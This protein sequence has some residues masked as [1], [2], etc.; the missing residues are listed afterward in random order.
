[1]VAWVLQYFL[2]WWWSV[3]EPSS[4]VT[5]S[6]VWLLSSWSVASAPEALMFSLYF[7]LSSNNC[8]W[9]MYGIKSISYQCTL[10][11]ELISSEALGHPWGHLLLTSSP[12][13]PLQSG[14]CQEWRHMPCAVVSPGF[15]FHTT[16]KT[17]VCLGMGERSWNPSKWFG[18]YFRGLLFLNHIQEELKGY[19][20]PAS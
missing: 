8:M 5:P 1:M 9:L 11:V 2:P 16:T 12:P 15:D 20:F 4:V 13:P 10:E 14:L 17:I 6:H 18:R 3:P 19:R 7:T